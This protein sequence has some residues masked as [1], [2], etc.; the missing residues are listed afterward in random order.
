MS[1]DRGVLGVGLAVVLLWTGCSGKPKVAYKDL[2]DADPAVRSDAAVRL[3]QARSKDAVDSL[4]AVLGDPEETVRV[5]VIRALGEIGDPKAVPAIVP[6]VADPSSG[7]RIASCQALGQLGDAQGVPALAGA[8]YDQDDTIRLVAVRSLGTIP[9]PASLD[10]L[11]RV[12]LQDESEV[13]RSHVVKVVGERH[14]KDAV[15]KLESALQAESERVRANAATALGDIGD[16][17]SLPTLLRALD[18]PYFKVRCLAAHAIA[19]LAPG[20][21]AAKAALTAR[22]GVE[23]NGMAKVDIAWAL[24]TMGDRSRLD[25]VRTLLFQG[26]PEDVRAEAA[27]ALGAL[28]GPSDLPILDKAL[29]DKKGLVR[30]RAAEAIDKIKDARTS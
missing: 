8:L 11:V 23:T 2:V 10:V 15:P 22:L 6:F 13:I 4:V 25:V 7:V 20:D 14:A 9:G 21:A 26:E 18:D 29:A 24:G 27:L 17:S 3:G 12:A 1:L 30:N 28:G 5:N 19:K 16:L